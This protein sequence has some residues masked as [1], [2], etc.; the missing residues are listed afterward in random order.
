MI[1][2]GNICPCCGATLVKCSSSGY[3]VL[4]ECSEKDCPYQITGTAEKPIEPI[5]YSKF[6]GHTPGPWWTNLPKG[7]IY[8]DGYANGLY[9]LAVAH[10]DTCGGVAEFEAN[11]NLIAGAPALLAR[12]KELEE[13]KKIMTMCILKPRA[14]CGEC[15]AENN[16]CI[17]RKLIKR[18]A[19]K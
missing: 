2:F 15:M 6:E 11:V 16:C 18:E 19:A 12:C 1:E 4:Y 17:S 3:N 10:G 8:T 13:F 7:G 14:D 5:D 9:S